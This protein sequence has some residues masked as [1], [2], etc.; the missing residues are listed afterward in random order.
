MDELRARLE[1]ELGDRVRTDPGTLSAHR[2]DSWVLSDLLDLEGRAAP[3]PLAVVE[4]R[5]TEDIQ[6]TLR[7]CRELRVPVVP[8]GGGSGVCGA[9]RSSER[10]V[11]LLTR[12]LDGLVALDDTNLTAS[13]RAGTLGIDAERR[14]QQA[15][16]TIGHWPQSIEI[17]TVGGWVATRA[18]GR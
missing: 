13:F 14:V 1:K 10:T 3:S 18:A 4:A 16:L 17:S 11:V 7:L 2:H 12:A 8:F 5:S 15:G 6:R 9:I